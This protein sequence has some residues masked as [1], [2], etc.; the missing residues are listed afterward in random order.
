MKR[1]CGVVCVLALASTMALAKKDKKKAA[2][3][4]KDPM[5]EAMA[6]YATPGP[7]HKMLKS[8]VGSWTVSGKFWMPGGKPPV[9]STS[10]CEMKAI[11]DIW[12]TEDVSGDFMG[13]PFTGHGVMGYDLAKQKYV[14]TWVDNM[15]SYIMNSEGTADASGKVITSTGND[16]DPMTGKTGTVK[17]VMT[18]DSDTKH[19]MAMYKAG[20]DGKE[21]KMME[22]VYTKK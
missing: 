15:G 2:E 5:M 18:I 20:P 1:I 12:V 13:H 6:K 4:A 11:G 22:L 10:N 17:E 14:S 9:E 21:M 8:M 3:P 19:T 16:F 7:Q